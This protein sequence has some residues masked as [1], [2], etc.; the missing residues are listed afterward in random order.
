[1]D[2][3]TLDRSPI[4]NFTAN[5]M[6]ILNENATSFSNVI[7]SIQFA[8]NPY[9]TSP[10]SSS[11][12]FLP[13]EENALALRDCF[14]QLGLQLPSFL[15]RVYLL[16]REFALFSERASTRY[17][18]R[19]S[20]DFILHT[21]N[22]RDPS[23]RG[24]SRCLDIHQALLSLRSRGH[25]LH[26]SSQLSLFAP[27]SLSWSE[28][29]R[30]R[31][32]SM[33]ASRESF[34]SF[35]LRSPPNRTSSGASEMSRRS[36]EAT[37]TFPDIH[38]VTPLLAS[39]ALFDGRR[40]VEDELGDFQLPSS[41][42]DYRRG[43]M[44]ARLLNSSVDVPSR[45]S[46]DA[47]RHSL[48]MS[49]NSL[50]MSH[51]SLDIPHTS[52]DIP[53]TSLES[54][55]RPISFAIDPP[56]TADYPSLGNDSLQ[57]LFTFHTKP[58]TSSPLLSVHA[59]YARW[60]DTSSNDLL[61]PWKTSRTGRMAEELETERRRANSISFLSGP[62]GPQGSQGPQTLQ[63]PQGS[64]SARRKFLSNFSHVQS[65]AFSADVGLEDYS[66]LTRSS[67][68]ELSGFELS[69][70]SELRGSSDFKL[71]EGGRGS[72]LFPG[73]R[74]HRKNSLSRLNPN[75]A[76][77]V[78]QRRMSREKGGRELLVEADV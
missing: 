51:N 12:V 49:H 69:H 47:T 43:G 76:E 5:G 31:H 72:E 11:F 74:T 7:S 9:T 35:F 59:D 42:V 65:P 15:H 71:E 48:D 23:Y 55:Y 67:A 34:S 60:S 54:P 26:P 70:D 33:D 58:V 68:S 27:N 41:S 17:P 77:F 52:L 28:N 63:G 40:I 61:Q 62:Q 44:E 73:G 46:L 56:S 66:F 78:P 53:H 20:T 13:D 1:M 22:G 10:H 38:S 30:H 32:L 2:T 18:V 16:D 6:D 14:L 50:D 37:T 8:C 64:Q 4:S 36:N 21:C 24:L 25:H 29:S 45:G 3:R 75:S 19:S 39:R 57:S